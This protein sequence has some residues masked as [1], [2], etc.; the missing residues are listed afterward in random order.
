MITQPPLSKRI[1]DLEKELGLALFERTNRSVT[2]TDA[3]KALLPRARAVLAALDAIKPALRA[4]F[5]GEAVQV[6]VG[7]PADTSL[8]AIRHIN[9]VTSER[10]ILV[11][12]REATSTEQ[13][14]LLDHGELD[15]AVVRVPIDTKKHWTS[16]P[17]EQ[18]LGVITATNHRLAGEEAIALTA[19]SGAPLVMFPRKQV[20]QLYEEIID[21]CRTLGF[22]PKR[23]EQTPRQPSSTLLAAFMQ[24]DGAVMIGAKPWLGDSTLYRW[25]PIKDGVIT[26]HTRIAARTDI[27][28]SQAGRTTIDAIW[29]ALTTFDEWRAVSP[30]DEEL[31]SSFP[32]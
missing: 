20:P 10:G 9:E 11:P 25:H 15:V 31:P 14:E 28:R 5:G 7:L 6:R 26:W 18:N 19:L 29:R 2:L 21:S 3:G 30:A 4:E 23:I 24:S 12:V 22:V 13:I 17:L 1:A 16:P 32:A 27:A 8:A